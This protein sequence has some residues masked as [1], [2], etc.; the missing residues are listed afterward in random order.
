[1]VGH[2]ISILVGVVMAIAFEVSPQGESEIITNSTITQLPDFF[3]PCNNSSSFFVYF[4]MGVLLAAF[5][6]NIL[7]IFL[8]INIYKNQIR[9][10]PFSLR[11]GLYLLAF[12]V[13]WFFS[14]VLHVLP[15]RLIPWK[16]FWISLA[17][18]WVEATLFFCVG[19]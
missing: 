18:S 8:I 17:L 4:E 16:P 1:M 5:L 15:V 13:T 2:M 12:F 10:V 11:V 19:R 7:M 6:W 14:L 3:F 9:D